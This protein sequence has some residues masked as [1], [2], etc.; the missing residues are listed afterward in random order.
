MKKRHAFLL[1]LIFL[2]S[3]CNL[4]VEKLT[5]TPVEPTQIATQSPTTTA[6]PIPGDLGW[7]K[8]HGKVLD[9]DT[10]EPIVGAAV[11]CQ[12]SSYISPVTCSGSVTTDAQGIYG[13][14]EAFFHDTDTIKL[15]VQAAGYQTQELTKSIVVI[16]PAMEQNFALSRAP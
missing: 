5:P 11:T 10:N 8:I 16:Y 7:G 4:N 3:G 9:A 1:L 6:I 14:G 12:H 15:T 2:G 13:F